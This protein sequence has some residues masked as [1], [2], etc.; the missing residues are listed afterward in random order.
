MA[1]DAES[2]AASM[3]HF[4]VSYEVIAFTRPAVGSGMANDDNAKSASPAQ[5]KGPSRYNASCLCELAPLPSQLE[6]ELNLMLAAN[7]TGSLLLP[8]LRQIEVRVQVGCDAR[9]LQLYRYWG[10]P[11]QVP[12][13][14]LRKRWN[15][16]CAEAHPAAWA[17]AASPCP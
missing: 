3:G 16:S 10:H 9:C 5:F 7:F 15:L 1:D 2:P 11:R 17:A 13:P 8:V 14:R 12:G 4:S 6:V